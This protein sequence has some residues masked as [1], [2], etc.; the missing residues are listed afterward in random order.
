MK[1]NFDISNYTRKDILDLFSLYIHD[2][3]E[4][5][6]LMIVNYYFSGIDNEE[7]TKKEIVNI[8]IGNSNNIDFDEIYN[9]CKKSIKEDKNLINERN[10]IIQLI[11]EI[12]KKKPQNN[13]DYA[14]SEEFLLNQL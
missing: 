14:L 2:L 7:N 12:L 13:I 5:N 11:Y 3:T 4:D 8:L 6:V 1:K 9:K 10:K